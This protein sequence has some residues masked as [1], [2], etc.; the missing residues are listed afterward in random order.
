MR[1][2]DGCGCSCASRS[3]A[4]RPRR[5]SA[6]PAGVA[7]R[8]P[9]P[10]A[11]VLLVVGRPMGSRPRRTVR[12]SI[13]SRGAGGPGAARLDRR[14]SRAAAPGRSAPRS[15]PFVARVIAVDASA[16][17]LQAA[18]K[19]LQHAGQHR[20]AP[21]RPRSAADRRRPPRSRDHH[22]GAAPRARNLPGRIAEVARVL[23]PAGRLVVVDMLP[24][25]REVYRQQM[26]HVWLGFSEDHM[27][28][29]LGEAGFDDCPHR[30][31]RTRFA[32]QRTRVVCRNG[33][34]GLIQRPP[35]AARR[36]A[37]GAGVRPRARH[38]GKRASM[39]TV[40]EKPSFV[41]CRPRRGPRAIQGEGPVAGRVRPQGNPSRRAGD[42][43]PDGAAPPVRRQ[44]A[45]RRRAHHGQP[46]HDDSDRRADRDADRAR[47]RRALGVVQHLL[48]AGPRRRRGRRRAAGNRRN[49]REAEGHPGV[50]VEGR[51]AWRSTG[52]ARARRSSGRTDPVRR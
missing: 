35:R 50:R 33:R 41:R 18:R 15:R 14:R 17:M 40:T 32:R 43:R 24:H 37:A 1:P 36:A 48:D 38:E 6:A 51:D 16:A 49:G 39:A 34:E 13:P 25:D 8:A 27:R 52:G 7:Q 23:K 9:R 5:G 31:A 44:A 3:A 10:V 11:G 12:R 47:R 46:A 19:R 21:R 22:A 45:A 28:A 20:P 26:G 29:M 2:H 4:R 42:A 30:A